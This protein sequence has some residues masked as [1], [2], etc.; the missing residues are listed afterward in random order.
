MLL[1]SK[2]KSEKKVDIQIYLSFLCLLQYLGFDAFKTRHGVIF[3]CV[4]VILWG[5]NEVS[6]SDDY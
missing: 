6:I 3:N 4:I 1:I 2:K 5:I